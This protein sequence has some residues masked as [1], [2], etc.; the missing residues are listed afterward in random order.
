MKPAPKPPL[1]NHNSIWTVALFHEYCFTK[2]NQQVKFEFGS[3]FEF[4]EGLIYAKK[5]TYTLQVGYDA[6]ALRFETI[7]VV[8][9]S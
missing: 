1:S 5:H 2:H 9:N 7:V 3:G 4:Y 6:H 8:P